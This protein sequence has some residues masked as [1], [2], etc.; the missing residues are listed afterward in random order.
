MKCALAS[1]P[2]PP[3]TPSIL[4]VIRNRSRWAAVTSCIERAE[5][6]RAILFRQRGRAAGGHPYFAHIT[7]DLTAGERVADVVRG[8]DF[9]VGRQR[10]AA[11]GEAAGGKRDVAGDA[12]VAPW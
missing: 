10:P 4:S 11:L 3:R 9:A 12:D 1:G 2:M 5:E 8:P 6:V 7:P